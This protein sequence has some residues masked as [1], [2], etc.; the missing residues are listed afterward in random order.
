M[1]VRQPLVPRTR[2]DKLRA[3]VLVG[4]PPATIS[5]PRALGAEELVCDV[6]EVRQELCGVLAPERVHALPGCAELALPGDQ[7]LLI[8][9]CSEDGVALLERALIATPYTQKFVFHVKHTPVEQSASPRGSFLDQPVHARVDDL[10]RED[11]GDLGDTGNALAGEIRASPLPA[12][13]DAR[14]QLAARG[15]DAAYDAQE[16]GLRRKELLALIRAER[17]AVCEEV[18]RLEQARLT[19]AVLPDDARCLRIELQ[20]SGADAAE[21]LDIDRGQHMATGGS[22][23]A[24]SA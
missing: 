17:T 1:V 7:Q 8:P 13:F 16:V 21:I 12:V 22:I 18:N 9:T 23:R 14:D 10:D 4:R 2:F 5:K 24:A 3:Q 6:H 11:F 15:L 19:G 20:V